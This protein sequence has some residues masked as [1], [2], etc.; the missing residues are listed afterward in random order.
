MVTKNP[1]HT[2]SAKKWVILFTKK[3][4]EFQDNH[5]GMFIVLPLHRESLRQ[6]INKGLVT[7]SIKIQVLKM[8]KPIVTKDGVGHGHGDIKD[9]FGHLLFQNSYLLIDQKSSRETFW[10]TTS[11]FSAEFSISSAFWQIGAQLAYFIMVELQFTPGQEHTRRT[12]KIC[13][14][15]VDLLWSSF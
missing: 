6:M 12:I 4:F 3:Q 14:V 7:H 1:W 11:A 13:S 2:S 8:L 5:F 10:W 15:L 9:F